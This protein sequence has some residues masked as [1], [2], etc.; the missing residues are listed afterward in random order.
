MQCLNDGFI[1]NNGVKIPCIGFGTWDIPNGEPTV[2]AVAA[3]LKAGYRHVDCAALYGNQKSVGL[4]VRQAGVPRHELFINSK[5]WN[6]DRGYDKALKAFEASLAELGLDY[7]DMYLIHW[8]ATARQYD[9][10]RELNLSTWR[11]L[12]KVYQDGRVRA[13]GVSNFKPHHLKPLMDGAEIMPM[14][15]QVEYHPG[16]MQAETTAFCAENSILTEAWSPL[17]EGLLLHNATLLEIAREY[18]KSTAQVVIKWCLQNGV[19]PLP[20]SA[21]AAHICENAAVFDFELRPDA[22]RRI[23]ELAYLENLSATLDPDAVDEN[24]M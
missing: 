24:F 15:N 8:P 17:G 14:V 18:Q 5:V 9:D 13:I 12:E 11:A 23:N 3:A 7:L 10:W 4:A 20:R 21:N 2:K 22:M 1:L 19:L 16:E 6:T